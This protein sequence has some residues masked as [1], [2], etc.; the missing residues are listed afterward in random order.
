MVGRD[1]MLATIEALIDQAQTG[2]GQTAIVAGEAGIG[3]SRLAA[4]VRRQA[5][6]RGLA[7]LTGRCFEPDRGLPYAPLLDLLRNF[8]A[9]RPAAGLASA[10]GPAGSHLIRLLPEAEP[11]PSLAPGMGPEQEKQRLLQAI[12]QFFAAQAATRPLLAV[13]EDLHWSDD[14]SLESLLYLARRL[15]G[16]PILL[17]LTYRPEESHPT[18]DHFLAD[19]DRG[20]L[21]T[22]IRLGPLGQAEVGMMVQ[23]IFELPRPVRT[24]FLKAIYALTEGNPFFIEEVLKALVARGEIF[25]RPD[26]GRWERKEMS[27]LHIP[28]SINDAVGQRVAQLDPDARRLLALAAV[29]GRRFDVTLLHLTGMAGQNEAELLA[30]IKSLIAAQLVVETSADHFAFRHELTRQAIYAGM[31]TRER[32]ALHRVIADTMERLPAAAVSLDTHLPA[33]AYHFY[34]AGE[35]ERAMGYSLRAAEAAGQVFAHAEAVRHYES[36]RDCAGRLGWTDQVAAISE[37]IGDIYLV[38]GP[39]E[40]AVEAYQRALEIVRS[41]PVGA[42][43]E[44]KIGR[45]YTLVGDERGLPLLTDALNRLDPATQQAE[46]AL[47]TAALGRYYHLRSQHARAIELLQHAWKLAEPLDDA[48]ALTDIY[49]YLAGAY[50]YQ[51]RFEEGM[52]WALA[53]IAL[54]ERQDYPHALAIG[55]EYLAEYTIY[56][57]RWRE[58]LEYVARDREVAERIG[59]QVRL[60]WAEWCRAIALHNLGD[61]SAAAEAARAGLHVAEQVGDRRLAI[62]SLGTLAT[63]QADLGLDEAARANAVEAATGADELGQKMLQCTTRQ[64]LVT[65]HRHRG[66]T[67]LA[68]GLLD[69][70][71]ALFAGTE[72]RLGLLLVA[73]SRADV[74]CDQIL[75]DAGPTLMGSEPGQLAEAAALIADHLALAREAESVYRQALGRRVEGRILAIRQRW[76]EAAAA[77]DEAIAALS[78]LDSHLELS[79]ALYYRGTMGLAQACFPALDAACSDLECA[80][81]LFQEMGLRTMLWQAHVAL[82]QVHR[83]AGRDGDAR[84]EFGTARA[85]AA[86][87]AAGYTDAALRA[88]LLARAEAALPPGAVARPPTPRQAAKQQF[89]GLTE[90][91]RQVA[92]L[93]AQGKSNRDIATTLVLSE[94][95][96]TTHV[97]NILTK[98]GFSSRS[99]VAAWAVDRKL[100]DWHDGSIED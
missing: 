69:E 98:L 96:V 53:C 43:L 8:L 41:G 57:G 70:C 40:R 47:A 84:R 48:A 16:K 24:D 97:T 94:R 77:F 15:T 27:E 80:R 52:A 2:Q 51:A 12:V 7:V 11:P 3:K 9:G 72:N 10:L 95:T 81:T 92:A 5:E 44:A 25:R 82:G 55:F 93:I 14:T 56:V 60:G 31:L 85:A 63:I 26:D 50:Q 30:T 38:S 90:R 1:T 62:W 49:G 18:L 78:R 46:M 66:E 21:A 35:H 13:I 54:G 23:A 73:P 67:E 28:R 89:G 6:M 65:I 39:Y 83:L 59:A 20:R 79:Y 88:Q 4:E 76:D 86:D 45:L 32:Q 58:T 91:E 61:L 34:Q 75:K 74:I 37:Q 71:A 87:L 64:A 100:V 22:E 42:A 99:Q 36:A 33:L 17:L 68:A 19:V 29:A